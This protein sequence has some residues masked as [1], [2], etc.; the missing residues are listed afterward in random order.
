MCWWID[1]GYPAFE[2]GKG[3]FPRTGQVIKHYREKKKDEAGHAWTQIKLAKH[4]KI[5]AKGAGDIE[6][7]DAGLPDMDRRRHLCEWFA[8]PAPLLVLHSLNMVK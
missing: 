3:G 6:N 7:R 8:I 1:L 2:E 4:L 5:S